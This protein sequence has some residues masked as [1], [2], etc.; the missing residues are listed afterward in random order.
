MLTV[1]AG[2][3][4]DGRVQPDAER[5]ANK[6]KAARCLQLAAQCRDVIFAPGGGAENADLWPM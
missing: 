1:C 2:P 4:R 5:K 3:L 6:I